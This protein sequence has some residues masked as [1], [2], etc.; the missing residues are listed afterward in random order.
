MPE[1]FISNPDLRNV[2]SITS[3][4]THLYL[5]NT[6][7]GGFISK[8][9]MTGELVELK[10][11][12]G[13]GQVISLIHYNGNLYFTGTNYSKIDYIVISTK[14]KK[15]LADIAGGDFNYISL[16]NNYLIVPQWSGVTF[17][18]DL[19][20]GNNFGTYQQLTTPSEI[21]S[22]AIQGNFAYS[23]GFHSSE[24]H[25]I[26]I[27]NNTFVKLSNV[28][29]SDVKN[30]VATSDYIFALLPNGEGPNKICKISINTGEILN[31]NLYPEIVLNS[32]GRLNLYNN[33]LYVS[34]F[35]DNK[36]YR[37]D[38]IAPSPPLTPFYLGKS[39][40]NSLGNFELNN[41]IITNSRFPVGE[42]ELVPRA[43]VDS[44]I[45]SVTSYYNNII[46]SDGLVS[47]LDRL[48]VLE[49]QVQRVHKSLWNVDRD[50]E[51]INSRI[52]G[53]LVS[54]SV[55]YDTNNATNTTLTAN[56]P[57]PPTSIDG[58]N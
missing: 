17:K 19:T 15:T 42:T 39:K 30:V 28:G 49:A 35:G 33:K 38:I 37:V 13:L 4:G 50:V 10:W 21:V 25:K 56:P 58:L 8:F 53:T 11:K 32:E 7:G 36:I 27:L 51:N 9:L 6:S 16:Y 40:I 34:D 54:L 23:L 24:L 48:G 26:D 57:Q 46:D 14:E 52:N 31:N 12:E 22:L 55:E 29:G 2:F 45:E 41:V 3:D 44:Y 5:L 18:F 43:Y 1:A 20:P 47:V